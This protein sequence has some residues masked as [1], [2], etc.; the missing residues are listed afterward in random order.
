MRTAAW[1]FVALVCLGT[2]GALPARA[3]PGPM[4]GPVV[5][6]AAPAIDVAH[7]ACGRGHHYVGAHRNRSGRYVRAHCVANRHYQRYSNYYR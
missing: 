2:A 3:A 7:R 6:K 1:A 4:S 5:A